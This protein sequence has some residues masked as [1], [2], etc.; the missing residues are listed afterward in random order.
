VTFRENLKIDP[1]AELYSNK[2]AYGTWIVR[3]K[4]VTQKTVENTTEPLVSDR[5]RFPDLG[6]KGAGEMGI[7]IGKTALSP[8]W[9]AFDR[10]AVC[11]SCSMHEEPLADPRSSGRHKR[12]PNCAGDERIFQ[13]REM[14]AEP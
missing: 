14:P 12:R 5:E 2:A 8:R 13:C 10:N 11:Q 1:C 3:C 6:D 9:A 4:S 7:P